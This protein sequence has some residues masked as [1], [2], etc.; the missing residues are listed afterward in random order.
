MAAVARSRL[1]RPVPAVAHR[2]SAATGRQTPRAHA[3]PTDAADVVP[4]FLDRTAVCTLGFKRQDADRIFR[5]LPVVSLPGAR[6]CYVRRS[7]LDDLL[8]A[9]TLRRRPGPPH[10]VACRRCRP[11][12]FAVALAGPASPSPSGSGSAAASRLSG[13]RE[14][15]RRR[16]T[17]SCVAATSMESWPSGRVPDPRPRVQSRGDADDRASRRGLASEPDRRR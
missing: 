2:R 3:R 8:A 17:R 12:G 9:H 15:S 7:D 16:A 10:A 6:K 13:T 4:E 14:R 11:A 1:L 5:A